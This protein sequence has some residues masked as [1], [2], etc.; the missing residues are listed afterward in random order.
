MQHQSFRIHDYFQTQDGPLTG[1]A[2]QQAVLASLVHTQG[3]CYQKAGAQLLL[4]PGDQV[5]GLISGGCLEHEIIE[6]AQQVRQQASPKLV[7]VDTGDPL[8]VDFGYGLGCGGKLWILLEPIATQAEMNQKIKGPSLDGYAEAIVIESSETGWLGGRS[9]CLS[10]D[11]IQHESCFDQFS[12]KLLLTIKEEL[13]NC[14][15]SQVSKLCHYSESEKPLAIAYHYRAARPKINLYGC[16]AGSWPLAKMIYCMGWDLTAFDHRP[17]YLEAFSEHVGPSAPLSWDDP[18]TW[19]VETGRPH[20]AIVMTHNY[21]ADYR[22][23]YQLIQQD[24][25]YIGLLGSRAR[26]QRLIKELSTAHPE[27]KNAPALSRLRF[28]VGLDLGGRTPESIALAI[29][30]EAQTIW[31][32]KL[33]DS[34]SEGGPSSNCLKA[35][36]K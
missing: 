29:V 32:N 35:M 27:L 20:A 10:S 8:D 15:N 21:Q 22:I 6:H 30:S 5:F 33:A 16:G 25:T 18:T 31:H 19:Q 36:Q 13:I 9:Y 12:T 26:S 17:S 14:R 24:W 3:S 23:L 34:K 2:G 1:A 7:Y 11:E 28:P 4:S